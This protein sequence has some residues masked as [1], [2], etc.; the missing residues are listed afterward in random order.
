MKSCK[1]NKLF[2]SSSNSSCIACSMD[3][4]LIPSFNFRSTKR[5]VSFTLKLSPVIGLKIKPFSLIAMFFRIFTAI[6][7]KMF[8]HFLVFV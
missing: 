6:C 2:L 1:S 3:S 7:F 8:N 4:L 5:P